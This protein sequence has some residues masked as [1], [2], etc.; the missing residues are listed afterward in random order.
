MCTNFLIWK[1]LYYAE[2]KT[3][4]VL[5][6]LWSTFKCRGGVNSC[7]SVSDKSVP[8]FP[9]KHI[10]ILWRTT[11]GDITVGSEEALVHRYQRPG[12]DS[13]WKLKIVSQK[14]ILLQIFLCMVLNE[15]LKAD[16]YSFCDLLISLNSCQSACLF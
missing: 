5:E 4:N 8:V 12:R 14:L 7:E 6:R 10:H 16:V 9:L 3:G 2:G 11:N 13:E 1:L 15:K